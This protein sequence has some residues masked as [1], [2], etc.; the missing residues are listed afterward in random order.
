M[1]HDL[2]SDVLS[3][4]AN[5]ERVGK[6]FVVVPASNL[7]KDILSVMQKN[8]YIGNFEYIEDGR[9]GKFKVEL[10]GKINKCGSIRPRFSV[11]K[12]DFEKYER[13]FLPAAEFG[14]LIITTSRGVMTHEEAKKLGI[15]GKLLAY[16]Y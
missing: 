15:G 3:A 11:K 12:D 13:R 16:V 1:R 14:I 2:I 8:D 7:V 4:I 5:G 10:L 6:K 9:G